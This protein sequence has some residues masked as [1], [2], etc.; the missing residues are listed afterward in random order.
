MANEIL[1]LF[2]EEVAIEEKLDLLSQDIQLLKWVQPTLF[3]RDFIFIYLFQTIYLNCFPKPICFW[4]G[5]SDSISADSHIDQW[6]PSNSE[7][8]RTYYCRLQY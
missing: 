8:R 5:P 6:T 2:F 3:Y 1:P 4:I 7:L